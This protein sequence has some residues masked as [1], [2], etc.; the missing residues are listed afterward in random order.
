MGLS[1]NITSIYIATLNRLPTTGHVLCI[2]LARLADANTFT[3]ASDLDVR[4]DLTADDDV[5]FD[6]ADRIVLTIT[7]D[8]ILVA[9]AKLFRV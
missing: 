1:L 3:L 4:V 6:Q 2:N 7:I 5:L 9:E 8:S